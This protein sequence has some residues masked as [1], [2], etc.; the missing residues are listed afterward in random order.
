MS[1]D[2][3]LIYEDPFVQQ[4]LSW[5]SIFQQLVHWLTLL[6]FRSHGLA[7]G[8]GLLNLWK[9]I[10]APSDESLECGFRLLK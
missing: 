3:K 1:K 2:T 4:L 5:C 10:E 7:T 6:Q 8:K 9:M